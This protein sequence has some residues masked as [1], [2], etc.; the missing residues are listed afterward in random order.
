MYNVNIFFP[1]SSSFYDKKLD[2]KKTTKNPPYNS[3]KLLCE[4][5]NRKLLKTIPD[6]FKI[7]NCSYN[8]NI[9]PTQ[10]HTQKKLQF[11]KLY[12]AHSELLVKDFNNKGKNREISKQKVYYNYNN[13]NDIAI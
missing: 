8:W 6:A 3:T 7:Y 2:K 1:L 12:F 5:R 10:P 11:K 4:D 9:P 13:L